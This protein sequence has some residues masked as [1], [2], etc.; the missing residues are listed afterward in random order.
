[1]EIIVLVDNYALPDYFDL[2]NLDANKILV[3]TIMIMM[4]SSREDETILFLIIKMLMIK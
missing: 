3:C 4:I 2:G 1:M